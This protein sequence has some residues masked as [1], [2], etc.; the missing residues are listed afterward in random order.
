MNNELRELLKEAFIRFASENAEV[1]SV[2][3]EIYIEGANQLLKIL[4]QQ[5]V[6][7]TYKGN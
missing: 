5:K 6:L 1:Y 3:F 2:D 7:Q 4:A